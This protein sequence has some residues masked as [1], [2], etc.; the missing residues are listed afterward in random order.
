VHLAADA[1]TAAK[2]ASNTIT[3]A[4]IAADTITAAQI[5]STTITTSE[6]SFTPVQDT[7][8][9]ASINASAEGIT[10]EGD[11]LTIN[12]DTT[13]TSDVEI[14]GQLI[15]VQAAV[16]G[17]QDYIKMGKIDGRGKIQIY[18][19]TQK[20]GELRGRYAGTNKGGASLWLQFENAST[21]KI[22][23]L[24]L[25]PYSVVF[26]YDSNET[27]NFTNNATINTLTLTNV[28]LDSGSYITSAT[29]FKIGANGVAGTEV[30][31]S[32]R[33]SSFAKTTTETFKLTTG[34][35]ANYILQ[36]DANGDASWV[37]T[38]A[39]AA[40]P[41]H[42]S[43]HENGGAD[44]IS[45]AG[46]SGE[47]ADDQPPK[48]HDASKITSGTLS[49]DRLPTTITGQTTF[50][51]TDLFFKCDHSTTDPNFHIRRS[52]GGGASIPVNEY[53]ALQRWEGLTSTGPDTWDEFGGL[54]CK[55]T[56]VGVGTFDGNVYLGVAEG[57]A[58]D[59]DRY[60]FL[61]NS[62]LN[63]ANAAGEIQIN[64]IKVLDSQQAAVADAGAITAANGGDAASLL[65]VQDLRTTVN[66]L[67][68]RARSHGLIAT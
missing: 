11:N 33:N 34:A 54:T 31:G 32:T 22:S 49:T 60:Q 45:V 8:V 66:T 13:F 48:A 26:Q 35:A 29:G 16:E 56:D 46:L 59:F 3:A 27:L 25:R 39:G 65:D 9:I 5:A 23:E 51:N 38:I 43:T 14:N 7:D 41:S 10:I 68:A 52:G 62:V 64:G 6:L 30:I 55:A 2:I 44:E 28:Y 53:V 42:A 40:V 50:E 57:G 47:L 18:A 58:F 17:D 1:V 61:H 67:I 63:I 36:S 37:A 19:G 4:E 21:S 24:D 12:A 15:L 20:R